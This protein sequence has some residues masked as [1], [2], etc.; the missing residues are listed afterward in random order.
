MRRL[1]RALVVGGAGFY[2]GWLVQALREAGV[3]PLVLDRAERAE[4]PDAPEAELVRG[5][6]TSFD[7]DGL[8]AERRPDAVFQ[9]AGTGLVPESLAHPLDDLARNAATTVAVL[10]AACRAV[11]KPLVAYVSSAAVY[12][13]GVRLPMDEEHPLAPLS[14]YGISKLAAERYVALYSAMHGLPAFSVRPFSLYG[15][16]QRKLVVYDL[17]RRALGGESPLVIA[18]PAHVS[19]DF[20][21]VEDAARALVALARS[22][23][24]R[25]E[26]YNIASGRPTTLSELAHEIVA[27]LGLES[28]VEFT[29]SLRAGDPVRWDGEAGRARA[30]GATF[31]T[32]LAEGLRRTASWLVGRR[33]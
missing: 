26:A 3:E 5:D 32:P 14:P 8:L 6:V 25:G 22:A 4:R 21:Y 31:D 28:E 29:G 27:S 24:A 23:P 10:E 17:M 18:A 15:P 30:L 9:L 12:G 1:A 2:G 13:D 7:L 33:A 19:R 20:V 16:R 11:A